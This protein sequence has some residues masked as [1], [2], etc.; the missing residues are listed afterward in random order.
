MIVD[1]FILQIVEMAAYL[2]SLSCAV[3]VKDLMYPVLLLAAGSVTPG[4]L[5][6]LHASPYA[7]AV[8][9]SAGAGLVTALRITA[10]SHTRGEEDEKDCSREYL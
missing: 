7:G 3:V 9:S 4:G 8:E 2:L 10:L 6:F 1:L 5:F